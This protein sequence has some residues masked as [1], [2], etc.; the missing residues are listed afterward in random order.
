ML[1]VEESLSDKK[2]EEPAES[3]GRGVRERE[4]VKATFFGYGEEE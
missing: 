3:K 1:E 4:R 2:S